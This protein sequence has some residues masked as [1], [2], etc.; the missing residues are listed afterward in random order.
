MSWGLDRERHV[1]R[2]LVAVE[3]GVVG[4][5]DERVELDRLALDQD[6]LEGLDAE[7]VERG[8]AVQ[9]DRVL[10]DH[11]VQDVPHLGPL[12][13][14][15]LLRALDGRDEAALLE[16]VVDEGL[17]QL[18]RH[19]LRQPALV[20]AE[21]GA[22]HDHGAPRVVDALAEEVLAEAP[23]LAL[24]HV[25]ERLERALVRAGDRP[26]APPVVE[27]GV[28]RLLQHPLL[29]ADDDVRGVEL[30]QALQ[31][32]VAVD[33]PPVEVV[34]VGGG[35]AAAVERHQRPEIG[36][37]HRDDLEDQ[38][39]RPVPRVL[40]GGDDLEPLRDLLPPRLAG[41][42]LH[43]DTQVDEQLVDV[44]LLQELADRLRAHAGPEGVGPVLLGELAVAALGEQLALLER[45]GARIDHDVG[46]E[47]E[48][49]LELLER[50]VEERADARGQ[51]LQEPDVGDGRGQIDVAHALAADLRLDDLDAALLAHHAAMAHALVL[52]AVALVVLRRPEDL[53]AEEPV[54]LR[55]ERPV[56]DRLGLLHLA[57]RPR[58][59][60]VRRRERDANRVERERILGLLEETEQIFHHR[61][62]LLW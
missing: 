16:L 1:D 22:D 43:L 59:D 20:E 17:E 42:F 13:L 3:V 31:A 23:R 32:V 6:R 56:V 51:A 12:L 49:L 28:D 36:R 34:Q 26:A 4:G 7:A 14:D 46:L 10:A 54:P 41:R 9:E 29:V 47:V 5:T 8:R 60:L 33:D 24:E 62:W 57:M 35:E 61:V 55:L 58:P 37:D 45:G 50:H 2:H 15:H 19:L 38:P 52:A 39:L 44:E 11:L 27:E 53:G 21:L 30:H 48:D 25:G 40:E 18:E